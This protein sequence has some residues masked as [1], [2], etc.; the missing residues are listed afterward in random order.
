MHRQNSFCLTWRAVIS[1]LNVL[2]VGVSPTPDALLREYWGWTLKVLG[3]QKTSLFTSSS[4]LGRSDVVRGGWP[5][6][7]LNCLDGARVW[8]DIVSLIWVTKANVPF[9]NPLQPP[10]PLTSHPFPS[11]T[12]D[13][14]S[15]G[16]AFPCWARRCAHWRR[17][18]P[19]LNSRS[20]FANCLSPAPRFFQSDWNACHV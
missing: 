18:P 20:P 1:G 13:Y 7:R 8:R 5:R 10:L 6:V 14:C 16:G 11:L 3:I 9:S 19:S 17:I 15:A 12:S 4:S 2:K